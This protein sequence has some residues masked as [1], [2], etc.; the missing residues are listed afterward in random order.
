MSRREGPGGPTAVVFDLGGVLIRWDPRHLYR[1]LLPPDE[2]DPFL[3]EV[4]FAAWN[5]EQ[6]A[7]G[8]WTSA[9][10]KHSA[11]FPHRRDLLAAYPARFAETLDGPI[12]GTV[13]ILR[14]LHDRGTRLLALTNWSAETFPHAE[15]TFDFLRWFEGVVVSGV[16]GVA[17]P[18]PALFR[19]VLDRYRLDPAATV[20]VDDS[21]ANVD[22]AAALGLRA[23]LFHDPE[24]LRRDLSRL[25]LL[26]GA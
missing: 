25:G 7:G 20:F 10:E 19:L 17:K 9:V 21:P 13:E 14:E 5:H 1:R 15:E 16:E 18:D 3:D 11:L 8:S 24:T 2:V 22:A 4:G 23:L 12:E 26:D 6:D